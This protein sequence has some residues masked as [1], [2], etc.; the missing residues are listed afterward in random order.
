MGFGFN[1]FLMENLEK[2]LKLF[3][4]KGVNEV[5]FSRPLMP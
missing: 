4:S 5:T 1:G 2:K 3:F